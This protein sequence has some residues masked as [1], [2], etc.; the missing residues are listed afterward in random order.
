[1]A[2]GRLGLTFEGFNLMNNA[3]I[4]GRST[5]SSATSYFQPTALQAPRRFRIGAIYR[6]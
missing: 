6:F 5:R 3:A 2:I 4:T 1:M